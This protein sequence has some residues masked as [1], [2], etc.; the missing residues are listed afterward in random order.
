MLGDVPLQKGLWLGDRF[1]EAELDRIKRAFPEA[2]VS[3]GKPERYGDPANSMEPW[4]TANQNQERRE[5]IASG[6]W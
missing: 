4:P 3:V 5:R 6:K 2:T 1:S